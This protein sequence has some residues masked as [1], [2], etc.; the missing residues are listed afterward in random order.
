M[1]RIALAASLLLAAAALAG[2]ARPEGA[3]AV[4]GQTAAGDSIT[5]SGNGS[6]TG[7]PTSAVLSLGVDARA[8]T[9]RAA[10][11]ANA[12]EMRQVI[13]AVKSAGGRNVGTQSLWLIISLVTVPG[14][15]TPGQRTSAG[16]RNA[17]SQLVFFSLRKGVVAA[18][19]HEF[20]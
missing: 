5:V 18:S 12:R 10:V 2:V 9:A 14:L 19:G 17:P 16:T 11:A 8:A 3:R 20:A 4:D 7:V 1:K 6:V 13:D 15:I